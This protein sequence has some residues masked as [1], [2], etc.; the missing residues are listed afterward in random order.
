MNTE[1]INEWVRCKAF[2]H[3][4]ILHISVCHCPV[5]YDIKK[6]LA[7]ITGGYASWEQFAVVE[8]GVRTP[9]ART[10]VSGNTHALQKHTKLLLCWTT[11][12]TFVFDK[13]E[14]TNCDFWPMIL[15]LVPVANTHMFVWIQNI[16]SLPD[17]FPSMTSQR[18]FF[19][20]RLPRNER[21]V[22][23]LRTR[24]GKP[25]VHLTNHSSPDTGEL[26]CPEWQRR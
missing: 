7:L 17:F 15:T 24:R 25:C 16:G 13:G 3:K 23:G 4:E 2:H 18:V 11:T 20:L 9:H 12:A 21:R 8:H 5:N 22:R 1:W 19:S 10:G 6:W 26:A 14:K